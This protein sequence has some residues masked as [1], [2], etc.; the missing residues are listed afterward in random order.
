LDA[1]RNLFDRQLR[2]APPTDEPAAAAAAGPPPPALAACALM[3]ELA[4]AD[5][6]FADAERAHIGSVLQRHFELPADQ[7]AELMQLAEEERRQ[8]VDLYQFTSLIV[9]AYDEG[10]R[11][12][13][14]EAL[15]GVVLSDGTIAQHEQYLLRKLSNLLELRPGYLA[16][17]RQRALRSR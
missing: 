7:V 4:H 2:P 12:L 6:E 11:M 16:E 5:D 3:L 1:I 17:A 8:A 10:Q 14:A 13:L 15:W 9:E